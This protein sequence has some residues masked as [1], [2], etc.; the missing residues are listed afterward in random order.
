MISKARNAAG[1][2]GGS[3]PLILKGE[4]SGLLMLI[5]AMESDSLSG[6]MRS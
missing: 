2:W 6:Q 3:Q 4:Q 5:A 1:V